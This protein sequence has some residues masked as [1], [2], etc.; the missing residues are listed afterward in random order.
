MSVYPYVDM[1]RA[2]SDGTFPVY[3]IVKNVR[4]RF[5]LNSGI[6]TCGKL[7]GLCFPKEDKNWRQ[8]TTILGRILSDT[9]RVCLERELLDIDNKRL[10]EDIRTEVFGI[11]SKKPKVY[12]YERIAEFALSKKSGTRSL[13]ERTSRRVEEFDAKA[14]FDNVDAS[15]L[16]RFRKNCLDLGMRINSASIE[17]RNIRAVFNDARRNGDTNNYPFFG[18]SIIEEEV[19]PNNISVEQLRLLRDYKCEEWQEKYRDFFMLSFYLAGMN[20]VDLLNCKKSSFRDGH[21]SFVRQKTNKQGQR[22]VRTIVLPV[23]SEAKKIITKYSGSEDYLL[24]FMDGR[25]DYHSFMK[26]ADK[27]LKTIGPSE[28]VK[29]KAGKL[30]KMEYHPILPNIT[31]YTARYT[32]GSIAANDLDISER[33]IGMCLGHSWAKNVTSRYMANDQGKIDNA[34]RRVVEYV[35]QE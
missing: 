12:L 28:K 27:T 34:V 16:E 31:L 1:T 23:V 24:C 2:T 10:K 8:K 7:N 26:K 5:F 29:D 21:I 19:K 30:R 4:G 18:Y 25:K 32:F 35:G 33:T 15:W 6:S 9:Q 11:V 20:P 13:Y 22:K 17:L 3:I 14:T